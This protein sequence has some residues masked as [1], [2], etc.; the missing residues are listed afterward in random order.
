MER[1]DKKYWDEFSRR[2]KYQI[3]GNDYFLFDLFRIYLEPDKNKK[4]LEVGCSPGSFLIAFHNI[5]NYQII[6]IDYSSL[7][8]TVENMRINGIKEFELINANFFNLDTCKKYDIVA[9]FGFIEHFDDPS[10][11]LKKMTEH[12]NM[13]GYLVV[14]LPNRRYL[15]YIFHIITYGKKVLESHN[16]KIMDIN[17]LRHSMPDCVSEIYCD[18]YNGFKYIRHRNSILKRLAAFPLL[19]LAKMTDWFFAVLNI[20]AALIHKS[21]SPYIVYIGK[22]I[23]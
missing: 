1:T 4:V 16:L 7:D 20:K 9:S 19:L 2:Y 12:L 3:V 14:G 21:F 8:K 18:Y 22:L 10:S 17:Q 11:V 13:N 5:L 6:G 23:G 15:N